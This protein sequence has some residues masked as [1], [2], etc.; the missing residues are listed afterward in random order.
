MENW[1][2]GELMAIMGDENDTLEMR[3]L[4]RKRGKE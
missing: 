2:V 3:G 4:E 1:R